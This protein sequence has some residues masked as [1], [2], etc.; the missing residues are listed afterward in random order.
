[1]KCEAEKN[2]LKKVVITKDIGGWP[3]GTIAWMDPEDCISNKAY[4]ADMSDYW[5]HSEGY[6]CKWVEK[7][8][9]ET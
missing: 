7:N 5:Y 9:E 3:V 8:T 1:M 6:D 2:E 4:N